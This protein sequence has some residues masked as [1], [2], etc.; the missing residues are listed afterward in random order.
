MSESIQINI[1]VEIR[2]QLL[3]TFSVKSFRSLIFYANNRELR[4][5]LA[6]FSPNDG[7]IDM[8]DKTIEYCEM[9]DLLDV[10][11]DEVRHVHS[12]P[13][14]DR[15]EHRETTAP[16][17]TTPFNLP[18]DLPDF[19]GRDDAIAHVRDLIGCNGAGPGQQRRTTAILA[20]MGG[21]GKT[22]LALHVAHQLAAED[23]F[24]D[25][26][27]YIDLKGT[28]D[29]PLD[30]ADALNTLLAALLSPPPQRTDDLDSLVIQWR[31]ALRDKDLLLVLDNAADA[32]QV[33]P[34]LPAS[35]T[36]AILVTTRQRFTLPG[37][38]LYDLRRIGPRAARALLQRLAP[39]LG[40]AQADEIVALCGALPLA[41]RVAGN[42]LALND[43]EPPEAYAARLAGE[44]ERLAHLRDPD[45]PDHDVAAGISLSVAQLDHDTRRAWALLALF[46]A[47]FDVSAA[48]ALWGEGASDEWQPLDGSKTRQRIQALRNR[49]LVTYDPEEERYRQHDLLHL[50]ARRELRVYQ[51]DVEAARERLLRHYMDLAEQVEDTQRYSD[52]DPDWPHLRAAFD[53]A[54]GRHSEAGRFLVVDLVWAVENY[55]DIRGLWGERL[56]WLEHAAACAREVDAWEAEIE[57]LNRLG[58][59]S[60]DL[61]QVRRAIKYHK[62]ALQIAREID[63]PQQESINLGNLGLA[64]SVLGRTRK[65]IKYHKQALKISRVMGDRH[66]E[67]Q[68]LSNLGN[69]YADLGRAKRAIKYQQQ[70]L[71]ISREVSDRESEG[72]ILGNLGN[73]Y[74]DLDRSKR[75]IKYHKQALQ[76]SREV[77]DRKSEGQDLGNL[78]SVYADRD[79]YKRAIEYYRQALEV[80]RDIPD[81]PSEAKLLSNLGLTYADR[82]KTKRAINYYEQALEVAREIDDRDEEGSLLTDLGLAYA[83]RGKTKRAINYYEQALE[84]ARENRDRQAEAATLDDLGNA[85]H[86]QSKTKRA[87]EYYEQALQIAREID[88]RHEEGRSLT[89]LGNAYRDLGKAKRA[90]D[91]HQQALAVSR[92][93]D[94]RQVE[95]QDLGNLGAIYAQLGKTKRAIKYY[96]QALKVAREIDDR[97]EEGSLLTDL[98]NAYRNLGKTKRA[99]EYHEQALAISRELGDRQ[100]EGA[101]LGNLGSVAFDLDKTKRAIKYYEQALEIAREVGDQVN[102]EIWLG[103][104]GLA[105]RAAGKSRRAIKYYEQALEIAREIGDRQAEAEALDN[106]GDAYYDL[107]KEVRARQLW[108]EALAIFEAVSD[109]YADELR[110]WLTDLEA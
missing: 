34:L 45:D 84:V 15:P 98:G 53:Y 25:A 108:T 44:R 42:Y 107:D 41:L 22:A 48:A 47:P 61:G 13:S 65:A 40:D 79:K 102:E 60:R 24:A 27:L 52:L 87:I 81:R 106:L 3:G 20:G 33:R 64:Y 23:H 35:P 110:Q 26:Q 54:L 99:I 70:A 17:I 93:L 55:L 90:I 71:K 10:L 4:V 96:E 80:A 72:K 109:P 105:Y 68:D 6:Q 9:Y 7:L 57:L 97:D 43:D 75:A 19:T 82:G 11:L 21:V 28:D 66:G 59:A 85:Y 103:N 88:D 69:A 101:A 37:A 46:P 56:R 12:L 73:A 36:C 32:T 30:P 39:R 1:R 83:D 91:Y 62:Q 67:G 8:V 100:G 78:G 92:E 63:H 95:V 58:I 38:G 2:D 29:C 74:A 50:A 77:G 49:S 16:V 51:D 14:S 86:A 31:G 104:L 89:G 76:I 5:L 94:D 18:A